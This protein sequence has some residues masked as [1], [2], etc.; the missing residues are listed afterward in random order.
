LEDVIPPDDLCRFVPQVVEHLNLGAFVKNRNP[1]G[2]GA[3]QYDPAI[4]LAVWFYALARGVRSS[5]AVEAQCRENFKYMYVARRTMPDHVTLCRF[6]VEHREAFEAAFEE[7]L[8][9]LHRARML[10]PEVVA[11]DGTKIAASAAMDANRTL[12]ELRKEIRRTVKRISGEIDKAEAEASEEIEITPEM[13]RECPRLTRLVEAERRLDEEKKKVLEEQRRKIE[14][15][16]EE[17]KKGNPPK[18]LEETAKKFD[19]ERKINVTDPESR[20]L[21]G[22]GG[23][24][25]GC[26]VQA[27]VDRD[28]I[29]LSVAVVNAGNDIRQLVPMTD[30]LLE[31][32]ERLGIPTPKVFL[33]DAGYHTPRGILTLRDKGIECL[34]PPDRQDLV[35]HYGEMSPTDPRLSDTVSLMREALR[36]E[37]K[38]KLYDLRKIMIEPVFGHI[39]ESMGFR[40]FLLRGDLKRGMEILQVCLVHNIMKIYRKLKGLCEKTMEEVLFSKAS[41]AV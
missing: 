20:P 40:R 25:Q 3:P 2:D 8:S 41:P 32:E 34:I 37:E 24:I 6:R 14:A 31:M 27:V 22:R 26:N 18:S 38:R 21:K 13:M 17:H 9:I 16:Q 1:R 29:I 7:W 10:S 5:R 11:L 30:K 39:K 12:P 28:Q 23:V 36:S 15:H 35:R 4:L 33:P 19:E